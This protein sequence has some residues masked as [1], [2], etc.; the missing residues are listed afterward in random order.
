MDI[1]DIINNSSYFD[2]KDK[3]SIKE[4]GVVLNNFT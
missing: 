2:Q 3:K 4:N 1:I